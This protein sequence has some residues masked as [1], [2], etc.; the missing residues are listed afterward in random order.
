MVLILPTPTLARTRAQSPS[1]QWPPHRSHTPRTCWPADGGRF[2]PSV[3]CRWSAVGLR[4]D[5]WWTRALRR[6]SGT[7][8]WRTPAASRGGRMGGAPGTRWA[9]PGGWL[10]S[11]LCPCNVA[12]AII[13]SKS[14]SPVFRGVFRFVGFPQKETR[15]LHR[16]L[17]CSFFLGGLSLSFVC[18][19]SLPWF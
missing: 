15:N 12:V 17:H 19:L 8:P 9:P 14:S 5:P 13:E 11:S 6:R 18:R 1:R 10:K 4:R 16:F 2:C 7:W 3:R